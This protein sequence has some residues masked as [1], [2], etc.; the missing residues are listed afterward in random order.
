MTCLDRT[1]QP[2]NHNGVSSYLPRLIE[3]KRPFSY[4]NVSFVYVFLEIII[5]RE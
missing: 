3:A 5:N 2:G 1:R 4:G